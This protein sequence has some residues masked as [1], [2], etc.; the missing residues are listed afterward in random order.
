MKHEDKKEKGIAPG[1]YHRKG[2]TLMQLHDM[3]PD[4][5]TAETWVCQYAVAGRPAVRS[6]QW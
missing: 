2:I 1:R 5:E 4:D 6:L 3:F